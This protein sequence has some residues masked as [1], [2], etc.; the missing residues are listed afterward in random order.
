MF[1]LIAQYL[2]GSSRIL[3]LSL[4]AFIAAGSLGCQKQDIG[5]GFYQQMAEQPKIKMHNTFSFFT[6]GRGNRP[7]EE[8]TVARGMLYENE[9]LYSGLKEGGTVTA[10]KDLNPAKEPMT[11]A[12]AKSPYYETFPMEVTEELVLRGKERFNIYCSMCHGV[13]G[14]GNGMIVQRGYLPPPS[15]FIDNSRGL[16]YLTGAL[17]PLPEAPEGYYFQVITHGYGGMGSYSAQITPKDRWA[18]IAYIRALQ[19]TFGK[20]AGQAVAQKEAK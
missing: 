4:A 15:L 17:V 19:E 14:A 3:N 18:I 7:Y 9:H 8:G 12:Q 16:K 10:W 20:S 11:I 2:I 5:W 13:T 6:D 1:K